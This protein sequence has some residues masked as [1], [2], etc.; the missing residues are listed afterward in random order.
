MRFTWIGV[1]PTYAQVGLL[2]PA[3]LLIIRI[4]QGL[5]LGGEYGGAA[6]Y[7]A[8]HVPDNKRGYYTS[9][10]QI[11]ATLGLFV[12]LLVILAVGKMMSKEAFNAWGWRIPFVIG[13][14]CAVTALY[15]R[16]NM[17]ETESFERSR[18]RKAQTSSLRALLRHPRAILTVVGL[19][20]GGTVAFYTYTTYMLKFL[21]NSV[22][23]GRSTATLV[24]AARCSITASIVGPSRRTRLL[25]PGWC[26]T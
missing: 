1:L 7:V 2:A 13:A 22:G 24:S 5:A 18:K 15:L 11:T 17:A 20:L 8:E 6:V 10:I 21:V 12:S 19:T 3:L 26:G 16:R 4:A 23:M 9:F 14:L 25:Y